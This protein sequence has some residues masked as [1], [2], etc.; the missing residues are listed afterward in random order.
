V[1]ELQSEW[2]P[3][4]TETNRNQWNNL[5]EQ[6]D[7]GTVFHR[8]EWLRSVEAGFDY[9]PRH[10][11]VEKDGNPVGLMPNFVTELPL[12]DELTRSL[13]DVQPLK[14]VTTVEPGY[15]GPVT[16]TNERESLDLLFDTLEAS[17]ERGG[18]YHAVQ[19]TDLS[20]VRYGQYLQSRGYEPSLDTCLFFLDLD[21]DWETVRENMDKERRKD[22]RKA[23]EQDYRV[24]IHPLAEDFETTYDYYVQNVERVDGNVLPRA[25]LRELADRLDDRIRVFRAVVDGE[26]VGRYVH[27]LDEE[28]SVLRHWLSAIPDTDCY[29]YYPSELLHERAIKWGLERDYG[30]YGFGVTGAHFS[31]SVFR[32]KQKYG[33]EVV[34][35]FDMKKGYS[36]VVWPLFKFARRKYFETTK[37]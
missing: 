2:Y 3:T 32:F 21:D 20:N 35:L 9:E 6:A 34:P 28:A 19:S 23:N 25:F 24:E 36:S 14:R 15:G 12:P 10:V 11:V 37:R 7:Q 30:K 33:G 16:V 22:V 4:I 27:L 26:D 13:P 18:V 17:V 1:V 31:N 5:V 29:Q 8:Y